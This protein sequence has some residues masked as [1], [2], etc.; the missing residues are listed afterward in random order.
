MPFNYPEI[1][2]T[3]YNFVLIKLNVFSY[4]KQSLDTS[5]TFKLTSKYSHKFRYLQVEYF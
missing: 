5:V 1:F 4:N 3:T 2:E